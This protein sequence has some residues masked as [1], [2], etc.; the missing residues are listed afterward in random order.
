MERDSSGVYTCQAS[1][2]EGS[3]SH[4]TQ[5]LVLGALEG[6]EGHGLRLECAQQKWEGC[7]EREGAPNAGGSSKTSILIFKGSVN[8]RVDI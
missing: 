6:G 8:G 7:V 4:A 5:L 1:S 2:T 3:T